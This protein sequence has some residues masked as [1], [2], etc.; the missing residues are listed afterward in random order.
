MLFRVGIEFKWLW[1]VDLILLV[2]PRVV[3]QFEWVELTSFVC[4]LMDCTC[5]ES[6]IHINVGEIWCE[7]HK[8]K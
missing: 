4:Y 2:I 3:S 1:S 7:F 8:I 6:Y 5:V